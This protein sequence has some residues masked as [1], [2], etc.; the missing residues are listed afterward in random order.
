MRA[1]VVISAPRACAALLIDRPVWRARGVLALR[2]VGESFEI[3]AARPPG[4]QRPWSPGPREAGE[5]A[6]TPSRPASRY[7]TPKKEN[8]EAGD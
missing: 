8:L 2:R 6:P 3:S 4:Y 1:A 7:A 5:G